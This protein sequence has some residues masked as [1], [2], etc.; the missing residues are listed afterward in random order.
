MGLLKSGQ[1]FSTGVYLRLNFLEDF[2]SVPVPFVNSVTQGYSNKQTGKAL[3]FRY[4]WENV[5]IY[6]QGLDWF[7]EI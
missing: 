2:F 4:K 3:W 7:H 5:Y 1:I 6:R